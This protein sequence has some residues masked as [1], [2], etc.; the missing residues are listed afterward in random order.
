MICEKCNAELNEGLKFCSKC[1]N[2]IKNTAP[3]KIILKVTGIIFLIFSVFGIIGVIST[4]FLIPL[5]IN[6]SDFPGGKIG[7]IWSFI[8]GIINCILMIII[9]IFGIKY[10]KYIYKAKLLLLLA[11]IYIA[12]S[13]VS[14]II[15]YSIT[16]SFSWISFINFI[17]PIVFIIG[18]Y[19]NF[20]NTG[21]KLKCFVENVV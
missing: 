5:L 20:K 17:L 3:G 16:K 6:L 10:S 11:I 12:F 18:A 4:A 2:K 19:M 1:G 14:L 15:N 13:I 9:G 8:F 7:I 21:G